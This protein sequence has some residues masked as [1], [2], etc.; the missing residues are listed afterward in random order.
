MPPL[1]ITAVTLGDAGMPMAPISILVVDDERDFAEILAQRLGK[2]GYVVKTAL[3]GAMALKALESD[4]SIEVVVLDLA[5]PGMNGIDTLKAMKSG[6]P[7]L[8]IIM[9]TGQA[10]VDTAVAAIR[11]GAFNYL[12]KPCEIDDLSAFIEDAVRHR[13]D[14]ERK[15]LDVR[16][17]PYLSSQK[18]QE[19]I[20]AILQE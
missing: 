3:D 9:L 8:E 16:M 11:Q 10:T 17:T 15:I 18:R 6:N 7:L 19:L 5:M 4:Q 2:R 12:S 13:R 20:A 14:R 1:T